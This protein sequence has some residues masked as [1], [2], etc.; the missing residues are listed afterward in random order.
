MYAFK[1]PLIHAVIGQVCGGDR[2]SDQVPGV[3]D[4]CKYNLDKSALKMF[5]AYTTSHAPSVDMHCNSRIRL[6]SY[7]SMW[8]SL[9]SGLKAQH[10]RKFYTFNQ[11]STSVR[12]V[13]FDNLAKLC[14]LGHFLH[15]FTSHIYFLHLCVAVSYGIICLKC[16]LASFYRQEIGLYLP[17]MALKGIFL[18]IS[19]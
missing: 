12:V 8:Q 9:V 1:P 14:L 10:F 16:H 18:F 15:V 7:I 19:V 11:L 17:L 2:A 6:A 5:T 4:A 13:N 3:P